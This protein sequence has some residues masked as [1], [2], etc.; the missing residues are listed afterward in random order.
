MF[1]KKLQSLK[2]HR[3]LQGKESKAEMMRMLQKPSRRKMCSRPKLD[4][5]QLRIAKTTDQ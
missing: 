3:V 4:E 5:N 2:R 1:L